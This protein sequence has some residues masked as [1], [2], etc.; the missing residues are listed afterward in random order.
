MVFEE[1]WTA[2]SV[3]KLLSNPA[4]TVLL[5]T[6][7]GDKKIAG[8]VLAQL[9]DDEAEILTLGVLKSIQKMGVGTRLMDG[10]IRALKRAGARRL[11]LEVAEDNQAARA[12]YGRLHFAEA[13]RRKGYFVRP[14]HPAADALTLALEIE[15]P[16]S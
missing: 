5:A 8:F 1:A 16:A 14:G 9:V 4:A 6:Y 3:E 12:L 2:E 11:H 13:G 7:G 10:L 15:A